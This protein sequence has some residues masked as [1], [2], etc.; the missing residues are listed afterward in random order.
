MSCY[1]TSLTHRNCWISITPIR[2]SCHDWS[3]NFVGSKDRGEK[4]EARKP[5][6]II[7][8]GPKSGTVWKSLKSIKT[9]QRSPFV[10]ASL[11]GPT[12]TAWSD[13]LGAM[14]TRYWERG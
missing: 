11:F 10:F 3:Q 12:S 14:Q 7:C 2:L 4:P 8:D 1:K 5:C 9:S 13:S 6:S